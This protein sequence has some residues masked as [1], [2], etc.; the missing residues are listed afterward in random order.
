MKNK[1]IQQ[2][3]VIFTFF[4]IISFSGTPFYRYA[5]EMGVDADFATIVYI[6]GLLIGMV[7]MLIAAWVERRS[8]RKQTKETSDGDATKSVSKINLKLSQHPL[9]GFALVVIIVV[10]I[11][12]IRLY[13]LDAKALIIPII[14]M[15]GILL[16]GILMWIPIRTPLFLPKH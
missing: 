7:I 15:V 13:A 8:D 11:Y 6:A 1:K 9:L 14:Y 3:L 12:P 10:M 16:G 5:L 2:F 4:F